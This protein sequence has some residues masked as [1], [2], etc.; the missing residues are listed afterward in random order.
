MDASV[1]VVR[2]ARRQGIP[3]LGYTWWPLFALVSWPYRH[4]AGPVAAYLEQMGLWDL[5]PEA[6]GT[7]RRERTP[8]VDRYR[9]HVERGIDPVIGGLT[10]GPAGY[11]PGKEA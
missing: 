11:L 8:L 5:V 7:L 1:E 4:G 10:S 9:Q 3:V 6:D 2:A